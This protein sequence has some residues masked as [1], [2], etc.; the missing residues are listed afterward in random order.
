MTQFLRTTALSTRGARTLPQR[1][2][3]SADVFAE[4]Q[5]RIFARRWL[6][7]GRESRLAGAG[8]YLLYEMGRE[9]LI[10]LRDQAGVIRAL[11]NVCRH[12]GT[13]LC[14]AAEGRLSA[15]IQC[16]YHAWT[17]ALDGRLI[18]VPDAKEIEDFDKADYP[19]VQAAVARWEG[20]VFVSL[21]DEP[22]PFEEAFAPLI[23]R[24]RRWHLP[25]LVTGR[26]VDYDV[27]A[28]WKLLFQNY[29]ECY[30][31][32]PVHP[33]LVK[34]SPPTSGENDLVDGPV[35]GGFMVVNRPGGSL[36]ASGRSCGLTVGELSDGDLQRV[37]YYSI[38]PNMLLSLHHDYVMVH[39]FRPLAP[40][41]TAITCEFL[42][43][44]ETL[45]RPEF[46]AD[47][48][49][50]FWD[51]VNREDWHI[52]ELT[53]RGVSSRAYRPGPYSRRESLS[54]AFDRY[55][56][57]AMEGTGQPCPATSTPRSAR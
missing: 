9:S 7:V 13:R 14:E 3:V 12:R 45:V 26:R 1:A 50:R 56:R 10:V 15:T 41:R 24:L 19:L 2:Y 16:P 21:A 38:F 42:Y 46:D 43:H 52:C 17:Y 22:E 48:A 40:D 53:Q 8:D 5:E 27:A 39:T 20:F 31:C 49:V 34:L 30:H 35:L 55:Y 23:G 29:S 18:G 32:A 47:D 6:C 57:Q 36:T 44:P 33:S 51:M 28:N 4:E 37:Y 11:H 54:A 25:S